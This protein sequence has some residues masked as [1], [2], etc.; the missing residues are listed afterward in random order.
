MD[1]KEE[2]SQSWM[3]QNY[4]QWKVVLWRAVRAF[5]ATFVPTFCGLLATISVDKITNKETMYVF[6]MSCIMS[7]FSA[8]ITAFGK[9]LRDKF[10]DEGWLQKIPM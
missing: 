7:S 4:A 2:Q 9:V 5:V 3:K 10:E 8:G 1:K 6:G